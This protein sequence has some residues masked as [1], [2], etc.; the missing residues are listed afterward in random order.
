M[1]TT[2]TAVSVG[3]SRPVVCR[4]VKEST[5][6]S[7]D[8]WFAR[9]IVIR[10]GSPETLLEVAGTGGIE[11]SAIVALCLRLVKIT[12]HSRGDNMSKTITTS[13]TTSDDLSWLSDQRSTDLWR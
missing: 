4:I 9:I 3:L 10:C 1:I 2:N 7:V 12:S 6:A 8:D 13:E 11:R 5:T